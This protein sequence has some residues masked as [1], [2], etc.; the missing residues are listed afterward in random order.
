MKQQQVVPNHLQTNQTSLQSDSLQTRRSGPPEGQTHRALAANVYEEKTAVCRSPRDLPTMINQPVTVENPVTRGT[1]RV[2]ERSSCAI[3][4]RHRD[5]AVALNTEY[6]EQ[7]VGGR[8]AE[9]YRRTMAEVQNTN[10]CQGVYLQGTGKTHDLLPENRQQSVQQE[11]YHQQAPQVL[12]HAASI[13]KRSQQ[14]HSYTGIHYSYPNQRLCSAQLA[15]TQ[16]MTSPQDMTMSQ[17]R[18]MRLNPSAY[19]RSV[20]GYPVGQNAWPR[21]ERWLAHGQQHSCQQQTPSPQWGCYYHQAAQHS[22]LNE[23]SQDQSA[24]NQASCKVA[25]DDQRPVADA[26]GGPDDSKRILQF[27]PTMIRDQELLVSSMRQQGVSH[28]VM[29]RQFDALLNEQ[30]RHLAYVAQFQQQTN[31][32]EIKRT[33]RLLRR[34]TENDEKPEWMVHITPSRI[35]Y[36]NLERTQAQRRVVPSDQR[37]TKTGQPSEEVGRAV[38]AEQQQRDYRPQQPQEETFA[39]VAT[40]RPMYPQMNP[41]HPWQ[42]RTTDWSRIS[43]HRAPHG[44]AGCCSHGHQQNAPQPNNFY[45]QPTVFNGYAQPQQGFY[46]YP[47]ENM[48]HNLY[49]A[50][51]EHQQVWV[52]EQN[53]TSSSPIDKQ[54]ASMDTNVHPESSSLLKLRMYKD[55]IRLQK[56]NNGLQD[57]DTVQ[58]ALEALKDPTSRKGLEYLANLAKKKPAVK[59]NGTQ[60]ANEIPEDMRQLPASLEKPRPPWK[61]SANGLENKRNPDNPAPRAQRSRRLDQFATMEYPRQKLNPGTCHGGDAPAK[62]TENS[63]WR[64]H[65]AAVTRNAQDAGSSIPHDQRHLF[66]AANNQAMI[67]PYGSALPYQRAQ[68]CCHN[69]QSLVASHNGGQGDGIARIQR[70]DAP[71]ATGIDRAGGDA[72][73]ENSSAEETTTKR[74]PNEQQQSMPTTCRPYG[75]LEIPRETRAIDRAAAHLPDYVP[76]SGLAVSPDKLLA[77]RHVQ[78]PMIF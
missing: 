34:R 50:Y 48:P 26:H 72:L 18:M 2:F 21:D 40:P 69:R 27:T 9:N 36:N 73:G 1:K 14:I 78:P 74:G 65:A 59:L 33:C 6:E 62:S 76:D 35:S 22:S 42:Q 63:Q 45:P 66:V 52:E 24:R 57:P 11:Q 54:E 10:N 60:E 56:R 53:A 28:D 29:C 47:Y 32:S 7:P 16:G 13:P 68:Q 30:R 38:P 64:D 39:R 23:S 67:L 37:P 31:V 41:A 43:D 4:D 61:A 51:P 70:P 25:A 49:Q 17:L 44:F 19:Q 20:G 3:V 15:P 77:S 55:V 75:Q 12:S 5:E 8:N 71:D 58:K 46:R